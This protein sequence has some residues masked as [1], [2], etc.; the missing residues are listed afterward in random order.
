VVSALLGLMNFY[1]KFKIFPH[2]LK[3]IGIFMEIVLYGVYI[4]VNTRDTIT[5]LILVVH[6]FW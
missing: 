2:S 1:M 4:T 6:D 5:I 3:I